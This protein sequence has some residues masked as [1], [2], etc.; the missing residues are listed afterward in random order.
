[1]RGADLAEIAAAT[2]ERTLAEWPR[3]A[4]LLDAAPRLR[5]AIDQSISMRGKTIMRSLV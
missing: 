5:D 2:V 3:H 1:V 4:S